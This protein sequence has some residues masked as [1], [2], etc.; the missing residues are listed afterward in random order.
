MSVPFGV[1]ESL[2]KMSAEQ[3]EALLAL[4]HKRVCD[5]EGAR[6]EPAEMPEESNVFQLGE[7]K[8]I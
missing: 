6:G 8:V 3:Y 5:E 1:M 4:N 7:H 2:P